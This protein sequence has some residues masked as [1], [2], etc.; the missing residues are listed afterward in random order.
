MK[1]G[2]LVSVGEVVEQE[3]VAEAVTAEA[4]GAAAAAAA[5]I[6][7]PVLAG[8]SPQRSAAAAAVRQ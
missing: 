7:A 6:S 1:L 4:A 5:G 2:K 3:T 8:D